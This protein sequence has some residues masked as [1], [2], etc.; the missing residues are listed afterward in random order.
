MASDKAFLGH[1]SVFFPASLLGRLFSGKAISR[2][3]VLA[4][5]GGVLKR[6]VVLEEMTLTTYVP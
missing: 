3:I 1:K 6:G 2:G 4:A 5:K